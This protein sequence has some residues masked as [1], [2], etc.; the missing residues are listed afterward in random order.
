M[1]SFQKIIIIKKKVLIMSLVAEP[2]VIE[3]KMRWIVMAF[4]GCSG[5]LCKSC[6][7]LVGDSAADQSYYLLIII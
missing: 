2:I 7:S 1:V 4:L 3:N 6:K 5:F